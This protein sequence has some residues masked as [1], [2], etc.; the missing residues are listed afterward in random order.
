MRLF[1][2]AF[3]LLFM[4]FWRLKMYIQKKM[5]MYTQ[6]I[7]SH[8]DALYKSTFYL[9]TTDTRLHLLVGAM[10]VGANARLVP[11]EDCDDWFDIITSICLAVRQTD[12]SVVVA[13]ADKGRRAIRR[14]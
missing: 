6:R 8:D 3:Y 2:F 4:P 11:S 12:V 14:R 9:L 1:C 13:T 5:Y 10:L 7:R